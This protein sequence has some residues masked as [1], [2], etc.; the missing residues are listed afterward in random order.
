M[1]ISFEIQTQVDN[2][3][4]KF[5]LAPSELDRLRKKYMRE[6]NQILS[7]F[8]AY[9]PNRVIFA[10]EGRTDFEN[11]GWIESLKKHPL[12]MLMNIDSMS[13]NQRILAFIE[14]SRKPKDEP[15]PGRSYLLINRP[16]V[17]VSSNGE[18]KIFYS[19][20]NKALVFCNMDVEEFGRDV[21][22]TESK[23]EKIFSEASEL[24]RSSGKSTAGRRIW[25][26]IPDPADAATD[27]TS[28]LNS[29]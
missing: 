20:G 21:F 10:Y 12:V 13:S 3:L 6:F 26:D 24:K 1:S 8:P 11:K 2:Y 14:N 23:L 16:S 7:R 22:A 29:Y 9:N 19:H 15:K 25:E 17:I 28:H 5:K 4:S 18:D 27:I